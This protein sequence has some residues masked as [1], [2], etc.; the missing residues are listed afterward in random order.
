MKVLVTGATGFI[1]G[2]LVRE[3]CRRDYQVRALVR[4]GS[5]TLTLDGI[6]D[7]RGKDIERVEGDILDAE[8]VRRGV[9]DCLAVFHCAA[10]YTFWAKDPQTIHRANV[11]GT[12]IVLEAARKAN[13][14]KVVY[15]S[16]VAA[17]D[18]PRHGLGVEDA[19]T[20]SPTGARRSPSLR[21]AGHYRES[22]YRAEQAALELAERGLPVVVVNPTA[23]LGPWD[24]KPT[25]TGRMV[26]DFIRGELPSYLDT[27][28]N[29]V[30]VADVAAG[31]VL[32]LERG[33][34]GQRYLLGNRNLAFKELLEM[35]R[36]ITGQ[37]LPR[38][39]VPIPL[40]LL[41]GSL[42][43]LIE[44]RL[45]GREPKIPL[46]GVKLV[47][48]PMYVSCQKAIDQLGLPQSPVEA[49]LERA[50]QWFTD[51]GY[52]RRV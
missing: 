22:K 47:R 9:Q 2:N 32:A 51:Y 27:G 28:M 52:V 6:G 50:V 7:G 3:L 34:P 24:V 20:D 26:L 5:D 8:S 33:E 31:H 48:D 4:P 43:E 42:D 13:V 30:D 18:L 29:F 25:P 21:R 41:S 19:P 12:R 15:T 39:R 49:A 23:P 45:L 14:E 37:P 40:A 36:Q 10:V 46:D 17:L 38:F 35:L 44:G 1:G 16:T 11:D